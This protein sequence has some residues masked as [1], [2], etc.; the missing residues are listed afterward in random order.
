MYFTLLNEGT[1]ENFTQFIADKN[2]TSVKVNTY[3][4]VMLFFVSGGTIGIFVPGTAAACVCTAVKG[5]LDRQSSSKIFS[6]LKYGKQHFKQNTTKITVLY[7]T[8]GL[9]T[10]YILRGSPPPKKFDNTGPER[11]TDK[12]KKVPSAT[13]LWYLGYIGH[14]SVSLGR[15]VAMPQI[16][17]HG[18]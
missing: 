12:G 7:V 5:D 14:S 17:C 2:I 1:R 6:E 3:K 4:L 16:N 10:R 15:Q 9:F 13:V 11:T 8:C 18:I